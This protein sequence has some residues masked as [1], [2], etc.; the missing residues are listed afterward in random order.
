MYL[1]FSVY[2]TPSLTETVTGTY[3]GLYGYSVLWLSTKEGLIA[4]W[5]RG[6]D[7]WVEK[8]SSCFLGFE[9]MR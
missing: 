2:E 7:A 1:E 5:P 4:V 8:L 9:I 3:T 6:K